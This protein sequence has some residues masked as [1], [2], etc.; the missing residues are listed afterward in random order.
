V[1]RLTERL[2]RL[3]PE[4]TIEDP[5]DHDE[6]SLVV[7]GPHG[8]GK[9]TAMQ[10]MVL[11]DLVNEDVEPQRI[12]VATFTRNAR[13]QVLARLHHETA[14]GDRSWPWVRTIHSA[15]FRLLQLEQEQMISDA[16]VRS[17][18]K[19]AATPSPE[20]SEMVRRTDIL[21]CPRPRPPSRGSFDSAPPD[22]PPSLAPPARAPR[23]EGRA[24]AQAGA[25]RLR[26]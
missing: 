6:R 24:A 13:S 1:S 26:H 19:L 11:D 23:R 15:C 2:K 3:V 9:T 14:L 25:T 10:R 20:P 4:A 8:T 5:G 21:G 17:S 22:R 7:Y 16:D 18:A 12:M